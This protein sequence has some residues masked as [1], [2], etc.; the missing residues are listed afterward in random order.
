MN[1]PLLGIRFP[2]FAPLAVAILCLSPAVSAEA[3]S[4]GHSQP[5]STSAADGQSNGTW[6]FALGGAAQYAPKFEGSKSYGV[7]PVPVV[8]V[9]YSNWFSASFSGGA[10]IDAVALSGMGS[11]SFGRFVA[12]P[13]VRY[14]HGRDSGDDS[15]LRG[16]RSYD[17]AIEAGG[18]VGFIRGAWS[19]D[20]G[21]AQALNDGSDRGLLADLSGGYRFRATEAM[22]GRLGAKIGWASTR[23]MSANFGVDGPTSVATGLPVHSASSGIKDAGVSLSFR[24]ELRGGV[25]LDMLGGY[26]RLVG[27]AAESPLVA[28]RGSK[29]QFVTGA[30]LSWRF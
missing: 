15:A 19:I 22:T 20:L 27:A 3:H 11:T 2:R 12:G 21:V 9:G 8:E 6:R 13:L 10:R 7:K 24:H 30:G 5:A 23:Y 18:F 4:P 14:R 25:G 1:L 29:N 17:G 26:T 28:R 16:F